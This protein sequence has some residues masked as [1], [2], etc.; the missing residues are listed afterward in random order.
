MPGSLDEATFRQLWTTSPRTARAR[1]ARAVRRHEPAYDPVRELRDPR[2]YP[3]PCAHVGCGRVVVVSG[4]WPQRRYCSLACREAASY[5]R[6]RDK[7]VL[8]GPLPCPNCGA[9]F[10]PTHNRQVYCTPACAGRGQRRRYRERRRRERA[11]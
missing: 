7:P 2:A 9:S 3:R 5:R 10:A 11:P 4:W 1:Y 6:R 8:P